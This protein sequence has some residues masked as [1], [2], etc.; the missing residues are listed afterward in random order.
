MFKE[1]KIMFL[2]TETSLHCGSGSSLGVVDLPIQRE[3]YT[4][5]PIAQASGVKGA[6]REWFETRDRKNQNKDREK[7]KYIFGPELERDEKLEFAGAVTFTDARL[8]LFPVRSLRGV[9]AYCTSCFALERLKRDLTIAGKSVQWN[10]PAEPGS[11][12]V[13]GIQAGND[14]SDGSGVLLE[15]FAFHFTQD[16]AVTK[17]AAWLAQ[18]AFPQ[19]NEYKFWRDKVMKSLLVL[20]ENAFRDFVKLATEV[21][22]RIR[23][24]NESKTVAKGALF[25]EETLPSD[26]LLYSIVMANDP[27]TDWGSRPE[28]LKSAADV[29]KLVTELSDKRTQFGGDSSIGRGIVYVN[30]LIKEDSDATNAGAKTS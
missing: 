2:Y 9:F 3:R 21:Q 29:I 11:D 28:G 16:T 18:N 5:Y 13:L 22:A 23:I 12:K 17:I 14:I 10:V 30:F 19:E 26:S 1:A 4:D 25:Y 24:N 8:L 7:I 27:A 6:I 15:D 20:P